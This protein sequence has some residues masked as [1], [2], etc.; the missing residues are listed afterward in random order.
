MTSPHDHEWLEETT[1]LSPVVDLY[2]TVCGETR[3]EPKE[4][5]EQ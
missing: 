1:L 3:T 5:F 2:C 4:G